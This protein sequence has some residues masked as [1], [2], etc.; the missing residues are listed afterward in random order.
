MQAIREESGKSWIVDS[1]KNTRLNYHRLSLLSKHMGC[2]VKVIHL[3]RDPRA[4]MWSAGRGS[5]RQLESNGRLGGRMRNMLSGLMSW[6]FS[7]V[8]VEALC[9]QHPG[10]SVHQV[11]Y[12]DLVS[13]P[14]ETL[15]QIGQFL[16]LDLQEISTCIQ[17]GGSFMSGHGIAG[18]RMRR[19]GEIVLRLDCEWESKLP[20]AANALSLVAWPLLRKYRY[21]T[22][23]KK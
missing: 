10:W 11:R 21:I 9:S 12:E 16:E 22:T 5:N 6:M 4:V 17:E 20:R 19:S 2:P 23:S 3:V 13:A 18:N 14:E 1:S 15:K 7:N 8:T